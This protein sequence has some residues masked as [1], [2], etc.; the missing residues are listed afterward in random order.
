MI[1]PARP[2]VKQCRT[3]GITI[4]GWAVSLGRIEGDGVP[5][6]VA[7]REWALGSEGTPGFAFDNELRGQSVALRA[8]EIDAAPVTWARFLPF[9]EAGG[10]GDERFWLRLASARKS[11]SI[12]VDGA[13]AADAVD[14]CARRPARAAFDLPERVGAFDVLALASGAPCA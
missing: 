13:G 5:L 9:V 14:A 6:Q 12:R 11:P 2:A 4:C 8:F 1:V 3:G 7:A 10:Y